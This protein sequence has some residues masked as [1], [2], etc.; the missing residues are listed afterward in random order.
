MDLYIHRVER[1]E[2]SE[3]V[4]HTGDLGAYAVATLRIY[5]GP[6]ADEVTMQLFAST[7]DRLRVLGSDLATLM[8]V[9]ARA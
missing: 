5:R 7:K 9:E 2:I 6:G 3:P 8:Q 1:I 4:E